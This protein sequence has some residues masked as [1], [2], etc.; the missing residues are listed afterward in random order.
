[1]AFN[2]EDFPDPIFPITAYNPILN[3]K[4][5]L[6]YGYPFTFQYPSKLFNTNPFSCY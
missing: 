5:N 4:D 3:L 6:I 2:N 1:M